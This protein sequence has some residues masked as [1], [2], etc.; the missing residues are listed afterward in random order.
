MEIFQQILFGIILV[1]AVYFFSKR[2][3]LIKK[4]IL[5]GKAEDLHDQ[6]MKRWK[7]V[8][9]LALGQKKMFKISNSCLAAFAG[10][11]RIHHH[12]Y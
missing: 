6:P 12:Q 5:L 4:L 10:V 8:A 3:A 2:M 1:T 9:L 7:N 11:C